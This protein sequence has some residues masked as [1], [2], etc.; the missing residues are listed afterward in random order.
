MNL[1]QAD[2]AE[3]KLIILINC[4]KLLSQMTTNHAPR[5]CACIR[6]TQR[7]VA[8]RC[9]HEWWDTF[10]HGKPTLHKSRRL[11]PSQT[12][13]PLLRCRSLKF[14]EFFQTWNIV[15]WPL[16]LHNFVVYGWYKYI[17]V[18]KIITSKVGRF[19]SRWFK[20]LI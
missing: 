12:K 8:D 6:C 4:K 2:N 19:K 13:N 16:I 1:F 14:W 10:C 17:H 5:C 7:L 9:K 3:D 15:S 11:H 20:S 18:S